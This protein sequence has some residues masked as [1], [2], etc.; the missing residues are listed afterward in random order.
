MSREHYRDGWNRRAKAICDAAY[1][2]PSTRCRRCGLTVAEF[3]AEHPDKGPRSWRWQA[4][5]VVDGDSRYPAVPEHGHCNMSAGAV[6]RNAAA[7]G[8]ADH[9]G[10]YSWPS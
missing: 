10:C 7:L 4:G 3:R 8:N 9:L 1:A 2:D 6:L 5:H